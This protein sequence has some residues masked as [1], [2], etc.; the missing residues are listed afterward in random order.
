VAAAFEVT[1]SN[2][3]AP[4]TLKLRRGEGMVLLTMNWRSGKPPEDFVGFAIEF[5]APGEKKFEAVENRLSFVTADGGIDPVRKSSRL[6]P[7]QKFRWVH[8][9]ADAEVKGKFHYRV[10][11]VSMAEDDS[12]DYGKAQTASIEL[13]GETYPGKMNV[14]FTRGFVSSQAFV[15]EFEGDKKEHREIADL[16]PS[17]GKKGLSFVPTHPQAAE[18]YDWM[19]FEARRAILAVLD[20]AI[21]DKD[22]QVRVVAY[23]LNQPEVVSRLE[24]LGG[25]LKVIIDD[26]PKEHNQPDSPEKEAEQ[27]LHTSAGEGN[28]KR[29]HMGDLQHN[30]TIVVD[31][32][33]GKSVVCGSTNFSWRGFFVQ[34]NNAIVLH[35]E[36]AAK[37]FAD[38]FDGYW[39]HGTPAGF[40]ALPAAG[41]TDLE[42]GIDAQVAFSPHSA[43]NAQLAK[44]GDDVEANTSSTLLYSLAFLYQTEGPIRDAITKVTEDDA[45]FV[46][47]ISDKEAGLVL[48]RPTDVATD[49]AEPAFPVP[50]DENVPEPFKKESAGGS[51]IRMHHKFVVVDFEKPTARVYMGSYNFSEPADLS[52]GENLLVIK[53][54]RVAVSYAIEALRIFDHYHFRVAHKVAKDKAKPLV[55]AKPPRKDGELPWW[56][57]YYSR[58]QKVRDREVFA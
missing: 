49:N 21:A 5:Q 13:G 46:Y 36:A 54:R 24:Q 7:I 48:Q 28:V 40:G 2:D 11:P 15:D 57:D 33:A 10:T 51:G 45:I 18:A 58:P 43:A 25:R 55:L 30:K 35:G 44:V 47:G 34:S 19:G 17:S 41:L 56:D 16:L 12:L 50:L 8:F 39:N 6:S 1:G 26:S 14:A 27:R 38:A 42:L 3:S 53:D 20:Q 22:A 32:P 23:D 9:P 29:Q 31:G 37:A 52:N 4:F